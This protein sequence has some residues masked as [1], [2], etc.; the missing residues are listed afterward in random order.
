MKLKIGT[1]HN[2]RRVAHEFLQDGKAHV[3]QGETLSATA[4]FAGG[5]AQLKIVDA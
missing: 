4:Y 5:N 2:R 1:Q 3:R